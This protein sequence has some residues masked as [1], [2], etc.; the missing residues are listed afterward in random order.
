V[1]PDQTVADETAG[2]TVS[3]QATDKA[4][5][6]GHDSVVVKLDKTSPTISATP[7]GT[8]GANGWYT[9]AV[10]V[11]FSCADPGSV[12]SGV[13]SCSAPQVLHDG[14]SAT[15]TAK[16]NADN[17][18]TAS[19]GPV[20]V[21]TQPP[22]INVAGVQN[23]AIY[24]V[25]AVPAASCTATDV[26]RS[27]IDG[28][29]SV[30]ISGGRP[31][32]VG[33]YSYVATAKDMAGNAAT[34]TGSYQVRYAVKN[35]TAFWLQPINDTAHTT[36]ATTSVFKAGST[37]PAK[38][39]LFDASG[40]QIQANAAPTWI[41]PVRGKPM[42]QQ[43]DEA[44]YGAIG[45]TGDVFGWSTTDRQYQ[46]NWASPATGAGYYWRIGAALDDGTT[47]TISIGLR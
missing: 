28:A 41:A 45:T 39:R 18:G 11:S 34:V 36:G 9:T 2:Q 12:A 14:E 27:G 25:G 44:A 29:C 16:D 1:T 20:K 37:I 3:G 31:N 17:T 40:N 30:T 43:V 5:N 22:T 7:S 15:G 21:D 26:G 33:T 42:A 35:G 4:G 8:Q 38:F 6:V 47:Q 32:G 19:F 10:T 24:T 46:Y 13:A 23:G